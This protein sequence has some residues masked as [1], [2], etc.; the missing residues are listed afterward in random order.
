M[1]PSKRPFGFDH[2]SWHYFGVKCLKEMCF[3]L[4][5]VPSNFIP[6]VGLL[7]LLPAR[8]KL[9]S[10]GFRAGSIFALPAGRS[11]GPA[12]CSGSSCS[13]QIRICLVQMNARTCCSTF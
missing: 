3:G 6:E 9:C 7:L 5:R 13:S 1:C 12:G 11:G 4:L 10:I 2:E 8:V